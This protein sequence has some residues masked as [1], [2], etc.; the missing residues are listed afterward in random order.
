MFH[1]YRIG[2]PIFAIVLGLVLETTASAQAASPAK[3][4]A[5]AQLIA[6]LRSARRLLVAADHDYNGHRAKAAHEV[7]QALRELGFHPKKP[8]SGSPAQ[9]AAVAAAKAARSAQ[10]RVH[11]PQAASDAQLQQ[12]QR[13]LQG[14]LTQLS[15]IHPKATTNVQNAVTEITTALTI[16]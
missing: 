15:S 2:C 4:A 6:T 5:R 9:N 7:T 12:A 16:K 10:A 13:L 3:Q 1:V 8:Q 11:E 14:A